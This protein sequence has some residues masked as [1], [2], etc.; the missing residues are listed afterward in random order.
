LLILWD[1]LEGEYLPVYIE[2]RDELFSYEKYGASPAQQVL[3]A[4]YDL[5]SESRVG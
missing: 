1:E 5:Y 4:A 2:R 3:V